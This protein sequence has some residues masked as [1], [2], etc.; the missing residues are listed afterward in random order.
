LYYP[1]P[2]N[3]SF[4]PALPTLVSGNAAQSTNDR[5]GGPQCSTASH[6]RKAGKGRLRLI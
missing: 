5:F 1:T 6:E 4:C 2:A 3:G